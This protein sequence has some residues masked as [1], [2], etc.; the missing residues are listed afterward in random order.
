MKTAFLFPGQGAQS[1]GMGADLYQTNSD[2][3]QV[4]DACCEGSGLDLKAACFEG[5]GLEDGEVVQPAI[6]AHSMGLYNA[7]IQSGVQAQA[8]AGLSLGEY[9]A[10]AAAGV[11]HV[12]QCAKLVQERGRI[13][14]A[15]FPQGS[16]GMLSVIGLGIEQV[17]QIIQ[18]VPDTYVANHLSEQQ[19]VVAG[20]L[21]DLHA[22]K[23]EFEKKGAKMAVLLNVRGPSHA[24]LLDSASDAFY[25]V[26][27]GESF[28]PLGDAAVYS[29]ALGAPYPKGADIAEMLKLQ[30]RSRLRWHEC[31]EHMIASGVTRF[32]EV[33]PSNVLS[34]MLSRRVGKDIIV[35]SVRDA[36][37]LAAFLE[38]K[39]D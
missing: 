35:K 20:Y 12:S 15:A 9:S 8:Y 11:L 5:K 33:G 7:L 18:G 31:V 25:R 2:Y 39:G 1:V 36:Q 16:A 22:L 13:M 21:T 24:P 27:K 10:L 28:N 23:Q 3:R 37:T 14:D 6:L 19:S 38:S 32:V 29:G 30:M 34:K 4:F 26:L 17:E